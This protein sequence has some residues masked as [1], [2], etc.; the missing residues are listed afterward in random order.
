MRAPGVVAGAAYHGRMRPWVLSVAAGR[1]RGVLVAAAAAAS[2]SVATVLVALLQGAPLHVSNASVVYLV[3]VVAVAIAGGTWAA[4]AC[5]IASFL[6]YDVLFVDPVGSL[7]VAEPGEWLNLLLFLLVA[8]AIGQ[9]TALQA[10]RA[11]DAA[12]RARESQALF[13]ISRTLAT[14]DNVV[15]VAPAILAGLVTDAGLDRAWLSMLDGAR[16]RTVADSAAGSAPPLSAMASTLTRRPGDEPARWVRAHLANGVPA[17]RRPSPAC[18]FRV[19]VVADG[20]PAGYLWG[21]R[22]RE[23]GDPTR[24]ETRLLAL[25]ADQMGLALKREALAREATAA[26]VAKQS[27]ALKTALLDSVSHDLRTPLATIRAAAGAL[28]DPSLDWSA[29]QRQQT[30]QT[31]DNEAQRLDRIVHNVLDMSRLEAGVLR[32]ELEVVP[33]DEVV[34]P[35]VARLAA[36]LGSRLTVSIPDDLPPVLVDAVYMDEALTNLLENAVHHGGP[37][38]PVVVTARPAGPDRVTITVED[39]GAGVPPEA[40]PRLFEKFYRVRQRGGPSRRGLGIGLSVVKGM[41]EAMDGHVSATSSR[42]GGLAVTLDLPAA[43]GPP[44]EPRS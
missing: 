28:L 32:P 33:V 12:R 22:A 21:V 6:L 16:E 8:V 23:T 26:E 9:L 7:T 17:Q 20:T 35:V 34:R 24:E 41:V 5:S 18:L 31:I 13:R 27:E 25:A 19:A 43:S 44:E 40:M 2:L 1:R 15:A 30:A 37:D 39:G 11:D 4:V 36:T 38:V 10:A 29:A 3:A 42:L 14:S